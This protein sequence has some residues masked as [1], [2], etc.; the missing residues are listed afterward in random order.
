MVNI[1]VVYSQEQMTGGII[2]GND[3]AFMVSAP[4]GWIMDSK[5]LSQYNIFAL[6]Y[7]NGKVFGG[8]TPIIY[9]NTTELANNTDDEMKKY[10][11][12]DLENHNKNKSKIILL[13][14]KIK[15]IND[16]YFIYNIENARG[17]FETI[18]YR[19]YKNT[20]FSII[21]NAP[22]ENI[23]QQLFSKMIDIVS[24]MRFMDKN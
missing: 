14:N 7:E 19:K 15:D 2:Y 17:Q 18:I 8:N 10:I 21:L 22:N 16:I 20:C 3:W 11:S 24:S 1:T 4:D 23:R 13:D 12:W 5:S 6:F 9:I